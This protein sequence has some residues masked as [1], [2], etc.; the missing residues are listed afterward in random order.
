[1]SAKDVK[2]VLDNDQCIKKCPMLF[3]S[4]DAM[5]DS[6][7]F[8]NLLKDSNYVKA[9]DRAAKDILNNEKMTLT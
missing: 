1:M 8:R 5:M 3:S 7:D 6:K 9:I 2:Q 4:W